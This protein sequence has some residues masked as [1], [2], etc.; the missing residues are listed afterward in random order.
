MRLAAASVASAR[1]V[2]AIS[3]ARPLNA[4]LPAT[5][6]SRADRTLTAVTT[7]CQPSSALT[8][9][10]STIWPAS[11]VSTVTAFAPIRPLRDRGVAPR[12]L[13]TP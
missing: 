10:I 2:P 13:S 11:T 4:A 7:G 5:I 6:T 1:S 8:I 12:R 3:M 9:T